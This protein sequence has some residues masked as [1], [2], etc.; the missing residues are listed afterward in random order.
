M[1]ATIRTGSPDTRN[2]INGTRYAGQVSEMEKLHDT[3]IEEGQVG[4]TNIEYVAFSGGGMSGSAYAGVLQCLEDSNIRTGV[5][6]WSGSSIGALVAVLACGGIPAVQLRSIL[7][8]T[9]IATLFT[10]PSGSVQ[11]IYGFW[12]IYSSLGLNKTDKVIGWI[13][14]LFELIGISETTTFLSFY[15]LTKTRVVVTASCV[16]TFECFYFSCSSSPNVLLID[17]LRYSISFPLIFEP[18]RHLDAFLVD[19]G[20]LDNLPLFIYDIHENKEVVAYNRKAVGFYLDSWDEVRDTLNDVVS[21][22]CRIGKCVSEHLQRRSIRH[23][24]SDCRI[25]P[26]VTEK[27]STFSTDVS[28]DDLRRICQIGY[29]ECRKFL[30][31]RYQVHPLPRNL[32]MQSFQHALAKREPYTNEHMCDMPMMSCHLNPFA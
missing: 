17:A 21:Y 19:G 5:K 16:D 32:F 29:D 31:K 30:E 24:Y 3:P 18:C 27:I 6:C 28:R 1:E 12:G 2:R 11:S 7:L 14:S 20:M 25:C 15:D 10:I 9:D 8:D 23:Q 4:D 26:I 13:L 22:A